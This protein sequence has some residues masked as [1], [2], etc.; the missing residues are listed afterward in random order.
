VTVAA[1]VIAYLVARIERSFA[2]A[3]AAVAALD[4]A[5]LAEKR[6]ITAPFARRVLE[7]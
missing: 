7:L 6:P 5:A 2:A 4:A 1:D 3:R